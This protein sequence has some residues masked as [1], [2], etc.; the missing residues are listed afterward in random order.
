MVA[1]P[2][3]PLDVA[4]I[5]FVA[6]ELPWPKVSVVERRS[7][8]RVGT[9]VGS[10]GYPGRLPETFCFFSGRISAA[11]PDSGRLLD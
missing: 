10:L 5:L 9:E 11:L 4:L 3:S 6:P 7:D 1:T 2:S 8:V